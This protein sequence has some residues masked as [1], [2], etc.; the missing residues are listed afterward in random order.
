[1]ND[2]AAARCFVRRAVRRGFT[3]FEVLLVVAVIGL[4]SAIFI[5]N[6]DSFLRQSEVELLESA[7]WQAAREA[8]L[9]ATARREPVAL[10]YDA[11]E[12]AFVVSGR[13]ERRFRVSLPDLPPGLEP[14]VVFSLPLPK[15]GLRMVRGELIDRQETDWVTYFGDGS[16]QPF[17]VEFVWGRA[18]RS[19]EIDPW[20]GVELVSVPR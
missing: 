8:R 7:F 12:Q 5:A 17:T 4:F 19:V 18:E 6:L 1:M 15:N 13:E 16:N 14:R 20:T 11:E 10:R 9:Q 3:L 2:H